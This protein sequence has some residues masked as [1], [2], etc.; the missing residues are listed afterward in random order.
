MLTL[1]LIGRRSPNYEKRGYGTQ[2]ASEPAESDP[3][4]L[5]H[6]QESGVLP[7]DKI[8]KM[9]HDNLRKVLQWQAS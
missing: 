5:L 7:L 1:A 3:C 2:Q 9:D 4:S 6:L 8:M